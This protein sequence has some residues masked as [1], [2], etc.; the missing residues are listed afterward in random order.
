MLPPGYFDKSQNILRPAGRNLTPMSI[1]NKPRND[2]DRRY[3]K[4]RFYDSSN[5][6]RQNT[7]YKGTLRADGKCEP[8]PAETKANG[9]AQQHRQERQ[10]KVFCVPAPLNKEACSGHSQWKRKQI[11]GCRT[12]EIV[13]TTA[14][15]GKNR[16][17]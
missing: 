9:M 1:A 16:K 8:Q 12:K 3:N 15:P 2:E 5:Q 10:R 13:Q 11:T 7:F 6:E 4:S 17:P 14:T